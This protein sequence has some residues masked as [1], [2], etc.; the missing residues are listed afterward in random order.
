MNP[1][2]FV[3]AAVAILCSLSASATLAAPPA[4]FAA[5][6]AC[7]SADGSPG[8]GPTMKGV[9]GRKAGTAAG[10]AFSPAMKGSGLSWNDKT[11]DAFLDNPAKVVPGNTMPFPGVPDAKQRA[12]IVQYLKTVK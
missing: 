5:C 9:F 10:F 6:G 2:A 4:A 3:R 12:E 11:L 7:H 8:V 1:T